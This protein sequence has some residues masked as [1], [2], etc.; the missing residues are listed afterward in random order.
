MSVA[1]I[2][3]VRAVLSAEEVPCHNGLAA[4]TLAMTVLWTSPAQAYPDTV[5]ATSSVS[6]ILRTLGLSRRVQGETL[7]IRLGRRNGRIVIAESL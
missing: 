7:L 5:P 1:V 4:L 3:S 2:A 6:S